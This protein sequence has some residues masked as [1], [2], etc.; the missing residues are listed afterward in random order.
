MLRHSVSRDLAQ[1]RR[2]LNLRDPAHQLEAGEVVKLQNLYWDGFIRIIPG[3]TLLTPNTLNATQRVQ[4]G[5]KF[6]SI[7][8]LPKRFVAYGFNATLTTI[9]VVDDGGLATT[10]LVINSL[11]SDVF[12]TTW[13][14]TDTIY[15]CNG[16]QGLY[17]YTN[18]GTF[19][20]VLGTN[21]PIPQ[22]PVVPISDRLLAITD[23]GIER[24]DARVDDVWSLDS[25]WA[26]FRPE[27]PG[28]FV[29]MHPYSLKGTDTI[30]PGVLALQENAYYHITGTDF[31][32]DVTSGTASAN[33]NS[34]MVLI[35]PQVGTSSPKSIVTVPGVG[36]LWFTSDKNVYWIPEGQLSGKFIGDKLFSNGTT[37]GLESVN[38]N[39]LSA[40][41]MQ[42]F[43]RKLILGVPTGASLI[44][45]T[46]FWLDLR[47]LRS[48]LDSPAPAWYGPMTIDTWSTVWREDQQGELKLIAGEGNPDNGAYV[49]NAYQAGTASH[50]QGATEVFPVCIYEDR[51][52]AF[53]VG[54]QSKHIQDF[55]LTAHIQGGTLRAG[56]LDLGTETVFEQEVVLYNE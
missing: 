5:A 2:G 50:F 3:S 1:P 13:S 36:V 44:A 48:A 12:F 39:A 46:Q 33:E 17:F 8:G 26:T 11:D 16:L 25:P 10:N 37:E 4:G 43:D 24:T 20:I 21:V 42:Y 34:A 15:W 52:N 40:V 14:I 19:G 18:D 35:D 30:F 47:T 6:Y 51:H 32:T 9:A 28:K 45:N 7:A 23:N 22:G 56:V 53:Q 49:Y 27:R 55:R 38:E 41:W 31:G 29:V 54:Q